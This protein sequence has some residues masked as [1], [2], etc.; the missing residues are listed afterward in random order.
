[1][2]STPRH[3]NIEETEAFLSEREKRGEGK[4]RRMIKE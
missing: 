4:K 2:T 1:M 3:K